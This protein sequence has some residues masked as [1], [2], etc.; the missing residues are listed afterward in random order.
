MEYSG[1]LDIVE[2]AHHFTPGQAR[3]E[4]FRLVKTA[5]TYHVLNKDGQ[6]QAHQ[7]DRELQSVIILRRSPRQIIDLWVA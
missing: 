4:A 6:G 2:K 5:K 7:T 3:I 1:P